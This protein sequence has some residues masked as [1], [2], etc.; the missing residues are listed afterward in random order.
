MASTWFWIATCCACLFGYAAVLVRPLP[1]YGVVVLEK[2]DWCPHSG[3]HF[4]D[5]VDHLAVKLRLIKPFPL[6]IIVC[7]S[8]LTAVGGYCMSKVGLN[9]GDSCLK[10]L[11]SALTLER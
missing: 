10:N 6:P 11:T 4:G 8:F 1:E 3:R 7:S 9:M 2:D 5:K